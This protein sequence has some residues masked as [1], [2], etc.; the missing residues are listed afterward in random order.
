MRCRLIPVVLFAAVFSTACYSYNYSG[1]LQ[2]TLPAS[3][4]EDIALFTYDKSVNV[5]PAFADK[6]ED[7]K[8]FTVRNVKWRVRDFN[9]VKEKKCHGYFYEPKD[10]SVKHPALVVIPPTGGPYTVVKPFAEYFAQ[11]GFTVVALRRR[12][13][14]FDPRKSLDANQKLIRQ[15]VIDTRRAIDYLDSLDYVDHEKTAVIG[16][17]LGGIIGALTMETD[18]RV[19]AAGF[20]VTAAHLTDILA[21]SGF[22]RVGAF[23]EALMRD[24]DATP[25]Q[26]KCAAGPILDPLDPATY[27]NRLDPGRIVMVNG[28]FDD[29]IVREVVMKTHETY[30]RPQQYFIPAGHYTS[31]GFNGYGNKKIYEHF[32]K[33]LGLTTVASEKP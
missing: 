16:I 30:G 6:A 31:I 2:T 14:F 3:G 7:H 29:I 12:Q 5:P 22:R 19:K 23:R 13:A 20:H 4:K 32:V 1:K 15:A 28:A 18:G 10:K 25:D 27:A 33:V 8:T 9:E 26:L 21:T 24:L 11:R 17:S